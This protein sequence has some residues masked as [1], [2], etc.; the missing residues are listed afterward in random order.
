MGRWIDGETKAL[1]WAVQ[2][3]Q[4]F[5]WE[6]NASLQPLGTAL[7]SDVWFT[8]P[9]ALLLWHLYFS[10]TPCCFIP[11]PVSC[12]YTC[13]FNVIDPFTFLTTEPITSIVFTHFLLIYI[14]DMFVVKLYLR[15]ELTFPFRSSTLSNKCA[16]L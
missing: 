3:E 16:Q 8:S 15:P 7:A 1:H 6:E 5:L 11:L 9:M 10:V 2:E 14:T 4:C 12:H 13:A